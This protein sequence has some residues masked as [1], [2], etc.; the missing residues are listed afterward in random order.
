MSEHRKQ[1]T[2]PVSL[3]ETAGLDYRRIVFFFFFPLRGSELMQSRCKPRRSEGTEVASPA[4][5]RPLRE[6]G[7]THEGQLSGCQFTKTCLLEK[8]RPR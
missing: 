3:P 6:R 4:A 1:E 5:P 8:S 7:R 2:T